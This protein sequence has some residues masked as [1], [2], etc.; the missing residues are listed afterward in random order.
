MFQIM[1]FV[2]LVTLPWTRVNKQPVFLK[3]GLSTVYKHMQP[4]A[5][6]DADV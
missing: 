2:L 3:P 4:S 1:F 6:K 5:F